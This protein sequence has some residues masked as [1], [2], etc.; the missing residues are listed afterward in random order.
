MQAEPARRM[1]CG[2]VVKLTAK[3]GELGRIKENLTA[4]N[5]KGPE[6]KRGEAKRC[7]KNILEG[8]EES[9]ALL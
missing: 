7:G 6:G 9:P 2:Q 1:A 4:E 8:G 3:L 5:P